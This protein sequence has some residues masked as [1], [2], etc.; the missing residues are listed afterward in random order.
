M[1]FP[2]DRTADLVDGLDVVRTATC[3]SRQFSFGSEKANF[4]KRKSIS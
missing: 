3:T 2:D 4:I 1:L